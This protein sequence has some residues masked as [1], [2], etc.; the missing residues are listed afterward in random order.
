MDRLKIVITAAAMLLFLV[1]TTHAQTSE[2][3]AEV[4][5]VSTVLFIAF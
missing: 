2:Q 3:I 1:T 4:N 5:K